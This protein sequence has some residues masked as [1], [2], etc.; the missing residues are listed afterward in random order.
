MKVV[1]LMMAMVLAVVML[2]GC[3]TKLSTEELASQVQ[4]NIEETWASD[5]DLAGAKITSFTLVHKE[6]KEYKGVLE[7]THDKES[8]TLSVDVTYDGESFM[9]EIKE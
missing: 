6:G 8:V 9:W 1:K 3:E 7:A 5:P 4:S 2:T